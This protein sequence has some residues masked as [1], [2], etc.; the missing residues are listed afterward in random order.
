MRD[1]ETGIPVKDRKWRLRRYKN[2]FVGS[3]AVT[4]LC[5]YFDADSMSVSVRED[6]TI[7][8]QRLMNQGLFMHVV[9]PDKDFEDTELFYAFEKVGSDA[10]IGCVANTG[11]EDAEISDF[12]LVDI[13]VRAL[14]ISME[15]ASGEGGGDGEDDDGAAASEAAEE[16]AAVQSQPPVEIKDRRYR[17]KTY[18]SVFLGSDLVDWLCN[19]LHCSRS[20]AVSIGVRMQKAEI[21]DHVTGDHM[22]KDEALF[23]RVTDRS[24]SESQSLYDFEALTIDGEPFDFTSLQ[25][26][27]VIVVNVASF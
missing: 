22:L 21:F 4:F 26:K 7:L 15:V 12:E 25:D 19:E 18:K 16:I 1:P 13:A 3:E 5:E 10:M 27:V 17:L 9:D 11:G 8:G 24:A 20:K 14:G 23:F 6:A 2:C